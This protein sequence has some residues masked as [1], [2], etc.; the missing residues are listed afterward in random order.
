M[1]IC[2]IKG[3]VTSIRYQPLRALQQ[4]YRNS[5]E[6]V[7]KGTHSIARSREEGEINAM[8]IMS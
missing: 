2:N 4:R 5:K 6:K 7:S 3:A 1:D 8:S